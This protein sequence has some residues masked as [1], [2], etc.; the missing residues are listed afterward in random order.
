M[1]VEKSERSGHLF[2]L[3]MDSLFNFFDSHSLEIQFP[4]QETT[5]FFARAIEERG[6]KKKMLPKLALALALK[7]F[8]MAKMQF[9]KK[10]CSGGG[11]KGHYQAGYVRVV[12]GNEAGAA[13]TELSPSP[14]YAEQYLYDRGYNSGGSDGQDLAYN[15]YYAH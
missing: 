13:Q 4:A 8:I 6:K 1:P 2:D 12:G 15:A 9:L 7:A 11:K 10:F 14:S 3:A 5:Q